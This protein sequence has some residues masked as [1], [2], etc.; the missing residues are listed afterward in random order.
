MNV[1]PGKETIMN[2]M[3]WKKDGQIKK[4][5]GPK[6]IPQPIGSYLVTKEGMSS[7]VVWKLMAVVSPRLNEKYV[8][9]V[10]VYDSSK[11]K[12]GGFKVEN[13]HSFDDHPDLVIFDGWYSK[14]TKS[15]GK[16]K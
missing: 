2:W 14:D 8:V 7:D 15:V 10:R 6:E 11:T 1:S 9:D 13:Y 16:R 3:F 5:P 4:L 12:Q